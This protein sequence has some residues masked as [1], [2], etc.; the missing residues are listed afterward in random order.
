MIWRDFWWVSA[1]WTNGRFCEHLQAVG[2]QDDEADWHT[3]RYEEMGLSSL[4]APN[5]GTFAT[6]HGDTCQWVVASPQKVS[7][8]QNSLRFS[9][10]ILEASPLKHTWL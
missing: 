9:C 8:P 3:L 4:I 6:K 5:K 10:S 7:A 1:G 2:P